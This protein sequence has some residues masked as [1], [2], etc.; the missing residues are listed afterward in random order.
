[1]PGVVA[2]KWVPNRC[3]GKKRGLPQHII[4]A[5]LDTAVLCPGSATSPALTTEIIM[6]LEHLSD[7]ELQVYVKDSWRGNN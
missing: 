4:R 1:M 5:N 3:T 6:G 2:A 7:D